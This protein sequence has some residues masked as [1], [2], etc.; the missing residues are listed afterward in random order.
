MSG[1]AFASMTSATWGTAAH[2]VAE[3][4]PFDVLS[5]IEARQGIL[6]SELAALL[7]RPLFDVLDDVHTLLDAGLICRE[8]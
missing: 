6:V 7:S 2:V 5:T 4:V 8:A 1:A 3:A